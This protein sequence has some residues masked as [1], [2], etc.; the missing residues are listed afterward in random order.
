M[1][2]V[3]KA[4]HLTTEILHLA[5]EYNVSL[6]SYKVATD[7]LADVENKAGP[8]GDICGIYGA[9]RMES[10]LDYYNSDQHVE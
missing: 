4:N 1:V 2:E 5:K 3:H 10:G 7:H 6:K 8:K 9:V